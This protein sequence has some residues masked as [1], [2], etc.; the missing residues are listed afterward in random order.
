[1]GIFVLFGFLPKNVGFICEINNTMINYYKYRVKTLICI[2]L[3]V[4]TKN[5]AIFGE[6]Y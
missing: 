1:M 4:V 3:I 6:N 2:L 5:P